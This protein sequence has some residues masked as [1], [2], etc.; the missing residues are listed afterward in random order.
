VNG[1]AIHRQL[2]GGGEVSPKS[3]ELILKEANDD[4]GGGDFPGG[5]KSVGQRWE[6]RG[7]RYRTRQKCAGNLARA[8][9]AC[10][11]EEREVPLSVWQTALQDDGTLMTVRLSFARSVLLV[12]LWSEDIDNI[13]DDDVIDA[14]VLVAKAPL[15]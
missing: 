12:R 8:R 10:S 3:S 4:G 15:F 6:G 7:R 1:A 14:V 13:D 2:W 5:E 11:S 9:P